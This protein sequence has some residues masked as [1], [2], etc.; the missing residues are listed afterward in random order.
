MSGEALRSGNAERRTLRADVVLMLT[1]R[2]GVLL[3]GVAT[4]VLV[5]RSL[6][7]SG[8]GTVA[9]ALSFTMLLVQFGTLGLS[10]ANPFFT[11]TSPADRARIVSNS[12]W[13]ALAVGALLVAVGLGVRLWLPVVVR[14]VELTEMAVALA[15]IPAALA[16]VFFQSVLLGEGRTVAYNLAELALAVLNF[17][18]LFAG[19]AVFGLGVTGAIALIASGNILSALTWFLLLARGG[20]SIQPPDLE[21]ARRMFGYGFRIYI[22]AVLAFLVVRVDLLLVNAYLGAADAGRYAVAVALADAMYV[23][24]TVVALNLFPRVARGLPYEASARVFRSLALLYG[25]VCLA[26]V[27][28]AVLFVPV[29][30]GP[31]FSDATKLYLWLL[32]GIYGYGMLNVLAQHF[33][34]RGFPLE[35]ALVW[36]AGLGLNLAINFAFLESGGAFVASVASSAAYL[37]LLLLHMRLFAKEAGGYRLLRPRARESLELV[38]SSLRRPVSAVRMGGRG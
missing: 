20:A 17:A 29:L 23:L 19:L 10:T 34:G 8:R 1:T 38:Q 12:V 37:L 9:V 15:A 25:G 33:A 30:F 32:P 31:E 6:G 36:F 35:A 27:P 16:A 5:A 3:L 2:V 4:T 14:G 11:A 18:V 21:L 24:P 26:S 7:P 13:L 22:A 28:F